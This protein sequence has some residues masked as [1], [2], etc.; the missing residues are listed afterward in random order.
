MSPKPELTVV[1]NTTM[2]SDF[3]ASRN[4]G[5]YS[6]W[7]KPSEDA[8][9]FGETMANQGNIANEILRQLG[10]LGTNVDRL[11]DKI[12]RVEDR[13]FDKVDEITQQLGGPDGVRERLTALEIRFEHAVENTPATSYPPP[14]K[15]KKKSAVKEHGAAVGIGAGAGVSAIGVIYAAIQLIQSFV[16]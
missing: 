7:T 14:G 5:Q 2:S 9:L 10:A 13:V 15:I 4:L 6:P 11:N 16:K 1:Q 8:N 3:A 12:D